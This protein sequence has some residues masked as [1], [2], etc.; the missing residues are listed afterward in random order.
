MQVDSTLT[1]V[2]GAVDY[3]KGVHETNMNT[4]NSA[5]EQYYS[6]VESTV[7]HVK[8]LLDP[9]PYVQWASHQVEYY[10]DPDK[11]VDTGAQY[12]EKVASFGPGRAGV[13]S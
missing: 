10:A 1:T 7:N 13:P 2:F 5:K 9:T 8:Q 6:V 12:A 3:A 4:F 11:I